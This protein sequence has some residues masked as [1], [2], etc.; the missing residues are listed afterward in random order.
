M[1]RAARGA[2]T[3]YVVG[4]TRPWIM[5]R[6]R[7]RRAWALAEVGLEPSEMPSGPLGMESLPPIVEV[8]VASRRSAQCHCVC[9]M[10]FEV[11]Y[12]RSSGAPQDG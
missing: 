6:F 2:I 1:V 12:D 3:V 5:P 9:G 11:S 8:E 7:V 10:E 4:R